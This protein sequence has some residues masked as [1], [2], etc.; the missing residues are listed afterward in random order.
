MDGYCTDQ[1]DLSVE[2]CA[3]RVRIF[4]PNRPCHPEQP[5]LRGLETGNVCFRSSPLHAT[6]KS[7]EGKKKSGVVF[8][9]NLMVEL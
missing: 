4:L 8:C 7:T 1:K 9:P 5:I 2:K 3:L 6:E